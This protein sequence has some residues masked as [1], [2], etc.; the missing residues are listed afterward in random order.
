M[1]RRDMPVSEPTRNREGSTAFRRRLPPLALLSV[2][3]CL[4]SLTVFPGPGGRINYGDSVWNQTLPIGGCTPHVTGF[5]LYILLSKLFNR[6]PPQIPLFRS[7]AYRVTSISVVFGALTVLMLYALGH[8]L[9]LS[10]QAAAFSSCIFGV[11]YTF[12]TQATEAEVYTLN[13]FLVTLS[14]WLFLRYRKTGRQVFL[15]EGFLVYALSLGNHPTII[16]LIPGLLYLLWDTTPPVFR[17]T[18]LVAWALFC[19]LLS[20]LQ[21]VYLYHAYFNGAGLL[22]FLDFLTGGRWKAEF[23]QFQPGRLK[24]ELT[25]LG[26]LMMQQFSLLGLAIIP[27][28]IGKLYSTSRRKVAFL[29]L[30]FS[31]F[32]VWSLSYNLGDEIQVYYLPSFLVA[33]VFLGFGLDWLGSLGKGVVP[34]ASVLILVWQGWVNLFQ[35]DILTHENPYLS[36]LVELIEHVPEGSTLLLTGEVEWR[37][38]FFYT[39][40]AN[41]LSYSGEFGRLRITP[42]TNWPYCPPLAQ[43]SHYRIITNPQDGKSED[44]I[45]LRRSS[46]GLIV[47]SKYRL[48][49]HWKHTVSES[50]ILVARRRE[51]PLERSKEP[52]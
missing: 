18:R 12:W 13:T 37:A 23:F 16:F 38:S 3:L 17:N 6:L 15:L 36:N 21:Y 19:V 1:G 41:Y 40:L 52:F 30:V 34:L 14:V 20:L 32:A 39:N 47:S 25:R 27:L 22:E 2:F 44:Q 49:L 35:S 50:D 26:S 10:R 42:P 46:V 8:E 48:S 5:P 7:A 45:Y 24:G 9:G 4:Y 11:S 43:G 33:A 28:G 51:P 31:C 29:L